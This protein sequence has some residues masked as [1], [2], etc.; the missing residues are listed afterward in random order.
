MSVSRSKD[1]VIRRRIASTARVLLGLRSPTAAGVALRAA[2]NAVL[3]TRLFSAQRKGGRWK[4][5]V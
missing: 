4:S 3:R 5:G 2:S 1:L